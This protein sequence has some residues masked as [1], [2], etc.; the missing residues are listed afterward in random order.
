MT[1]KSKFMRAI[2][3]ILN[4]LIVI[5]LIIVIYMIFARVFGS[6]PTDFQVISSVLGLYGMAILKLFTLVYSIN[7]EIGE[8]KI[9]VRESF[10]KI[11]EDV[12]DIKENLKIK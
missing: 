7:R 10:G 2:N 9:G 6:S 4:I 3:W 11:K 5:F 8:L 1:E 12:E